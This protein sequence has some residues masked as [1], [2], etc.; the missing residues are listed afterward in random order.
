MVTAVN[1]N[2]I[3]WRNS[4]DNQLYTEYKVVDSA[5]I[6]NPKIEYVLDKP[7]T[8][9]FVGDPSKSYTLERNVT[10]ESDQVLERET[11]WEEVSAN[12]SFPYTDTERLTDNVTG[13]VDFE[14]SGVYTTQQTAGTYSSPVAKEDDYFE[15]DI[16]KDWGKSTQV[17]KDYTFREDTQEL[18]FGGGERL[19]LIQKGN[20][21]EYIVETA[22]ENQEIVAALD[23]FFSPYGTGQ[24]ASIYGSDNEQNYY[25]LE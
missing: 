12:A 25:Q 15:V 17:N 11:K 16:I 9:N 22:S 19:K 18:I 3:T 21:H 10:R 2:D 23:L 24:N 5:E 1:G 8:I 7:R 6:K 4:S 14:I 13:N 20:A